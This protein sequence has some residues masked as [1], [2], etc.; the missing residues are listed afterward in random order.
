[1]PGDVRAAAVVE[2]HRVPRHVVEDVLDDQAGRSVE[3]AQG[4]AVLERLSPQHRREQVE[5]G[6]G[7]MLGA[8]EAAERGVGS[9]R[10]HWEI[11]AELHRHMKI[12]APTA[13]YMSDAFAPARKLLDRIIAADPEAPALPPPDAKDAHLRT[14]A[15]RVW[16]LTRE[17]HPDLA[18]AFH[19]IADPASAAERPL[20]TLFAALPE[21]LKQH[22]HIAD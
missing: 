20:R 17:H 6:A 14:T 13:A 12:L 2:G 1:M 3:I 7:Q 21:H 22:P 10:L 18:Q 5:Y 8:L 15:A 11:T 9:G 16:A 19:C 4:D